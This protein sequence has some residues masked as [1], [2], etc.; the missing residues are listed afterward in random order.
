MTW[1]AAFIMQA[2][3][4][5]AVYRQLSQQGASFCDQLHY[6]QMATEKLARGYLANPSDRQ[7]PAFTHAGIVRMLQHLKSDH[8]VRHRLGYSSGRAFRNYLDSLL[9]TALRVQ[10][11]VPA[12]AGSTQPNPEYPWLDKAT[13]VIQVPSRFD[14]TTFSEFKNARSSRFLKLIDQLMLALPA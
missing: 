11:L 4:E 13:N 1:R 12:V 9:G 7:P 6:L 2:R 3:H 8:A 14:F 5:Y 10:S